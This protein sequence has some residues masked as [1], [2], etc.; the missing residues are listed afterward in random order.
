MALVIIASQHP[1]S[2]RI[3]MVDPDAPEG[4]EP[5]YDEILG[6]REPGAVEGYGLTYDVDDAIFNSWAA[7]YP[8]VAAGMKITDE[9]E[10]DTWRDAANHYGYELGLED[11]EKANAEDPK[12]PMLEEAMANLDEARAKLADDQHAVTVAEA[13][14]V[15]VTAMPPPAPVQPAPAAPAPAPA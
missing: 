13:R 15:R 4:T 11:A 1:M 2:V 10:I 8:D 3:H 14:L 12:V 6:N 5:V 9:A 7:A